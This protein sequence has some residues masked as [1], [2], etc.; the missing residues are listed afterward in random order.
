MKVI[1]IARAT[2]KPIR[3]KTLNKPISITNFNSVK[4]GGMTTVSETIAD[5]IE[6]FETLAVKEHS[7]AHYKNQETKVKREL[8]NGTCFSLATFGTDKAGRKTYRNNDNVL[9]VC[10]ISI[11]IDNMDTSGK[12]LSM[13]Q[14]HAIFPEYFSLIYTVGAD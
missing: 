14:V 13:A 4:G 5:F 9:K 3:R 2:S 11:D 8:K 12:P 7:L 10:G 1:K 6:R